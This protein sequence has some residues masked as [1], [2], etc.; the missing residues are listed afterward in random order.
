MHCAFKLRLVCVLYYCTYSNAHGLQLRVREDRLQDFCGDNVAKGALSAL[1][2][3][4]KVHTC[5][6]I[7]CHDGVYR[8]CV[9]AHQL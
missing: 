2:N 3:L 6:S 4:T 5:H 8:S 7:A 9:I 1:T